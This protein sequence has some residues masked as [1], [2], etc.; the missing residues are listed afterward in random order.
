MKVDNKLLRW[1]LFGGAVYF[2]MVCAV[3]LFSFK[4][5]VFNIYFSLSAYSYQ[6]IIIS[7]LA[8]GW[9][10]FFLSTYSSVKKFE[11]TSTKYVIIASYAAVFGML[12]INGFIDFEEFGK[13]I[14]VSYFWL[15]T[16]LFLLYPTWLLILYLQMNKRQ[17]YQQPNANQP[18]QFPN[19]S[20]AHAQYN[21]EQEWYAR[22][23]R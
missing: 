10:M 1:S 2:F 14:V 23:W 15:Q 22:K 5:P 3:H 19:Q 13:K 18:G 7:F 20:R 4:I 11:L 9:G 17:E 12:I 16:V 21:S 8:F 6:N